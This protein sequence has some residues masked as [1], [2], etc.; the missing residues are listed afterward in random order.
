MAQAFFFLAVLFEK[1]KNGSGYLQALVSGKI[2]CGFAAHNGLASAVASQDEMEALGVGV[3]ANVFD[4]DFRA[5]IGA[6]AEADTQFARQGTAEME[7][8]HFQPQG[9][10]VLT[11]HGTMGLAGTDGDAAHGFG[12]EAFSFYI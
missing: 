6:A 2:F 4:E 3:K 5:A 11:G 12:D 7:L 8:V 9:S 10:A 1:I